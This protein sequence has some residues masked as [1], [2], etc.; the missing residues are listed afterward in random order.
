M[1]KSELIESVSTKSGETK[2]A[3]NRVLDATI[4]IVMNECAKKDGEVNL[5][6]FGRF[7]G[8]LRAARQGRNPSTGETIKIAAKR[9]PRFIPGSAF[10]NTLNPTKKA[11]K[12]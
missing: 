5:I 10:R 6:G 4:D 9:V 11:S 7:H 3:V 1:N 8:H 2:A 12:K